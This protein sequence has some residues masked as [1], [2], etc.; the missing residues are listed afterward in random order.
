MAQARGGTG[1]DGTTATDGQL[2]IGD[3]G[4]GLALATLTGTADQ[5]VVTNGA[6]S[7]T[8]STPQSIATTS[9]PSFAGLTLTGGLRV[10]VATISADTTL[11]AT[12]VVILV[13]TDTAAAD[14]TVTLP[15]AAAGNA[16]HI[17]KIRNLGT[18][19]VNNVILDTTG[20][21]DDGATAADDEAITVVSDG[22]DWF[23]VGH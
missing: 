19:G 21:A 23:I 17:Y 1:V 6:S 12:Q 20:G 13:D 7:I 15:A 10:P 11:T 3:T 14:V 18:G 22:T 8:L 5:V 16:G 2:L 4:T 9:S